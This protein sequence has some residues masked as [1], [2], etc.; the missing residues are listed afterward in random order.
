MDIR[1]QH[2]RKKKNVHIAIHQD[3]PKELV[4]TLLNCAILVI[5]YVSFR[6]KYLMYH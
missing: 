5:N 4:P 6:T 1:E 2:D 3:T